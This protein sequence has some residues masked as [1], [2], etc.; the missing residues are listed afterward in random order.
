[1]SEVRVTRMAPGGMITLR[2][3][4]AETGPAAAAV[5]GGACAG[6]LVDDR[7]C[8]TGPW[9]D[10]ADELLILLPEEEVAGALHRLAADLA[11]GAPS[12]RP[13]GWM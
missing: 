5:T 9:L 10:G 4:L 6:A 12:G 8:D 1:M 3:D 2:G 11:D 7:G 13:L